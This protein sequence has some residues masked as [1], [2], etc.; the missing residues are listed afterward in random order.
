MDARLFGFLYFRICSQINTEV[1]N[2]RNDNENA[3]NPGYL[4]QTSDYVLIIFKET[5]INNIDACIEIDINTILLIR[6]I[7][8]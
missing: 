4:L 3:E 2:G 1:K 7:Y 6:S 8:V 5:I